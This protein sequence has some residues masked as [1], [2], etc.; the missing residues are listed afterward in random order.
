[1]S[2]IPE[3]NTT[4]NVEVDA[5][6]AIISDSAPVVIAEETA[7]VIVSTPLTREEIRSKIFGAKPISDKFTFFGADV[8]LRQPDLQTVLSTRQAE[9]SEALY[10]MMLNYLYV[11]DTQEK[12]FDEMDIDSIKGL[13]FGQDMNGFTNRV[14]TMLGVNAGAVEAQV[15]AATKT[16]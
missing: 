12:V 3:A 9:A 5:N 1:M 16:A 15:T 8:E 2:K 10:T 7:P 6:T 11:P 4:A 14:N 13:P